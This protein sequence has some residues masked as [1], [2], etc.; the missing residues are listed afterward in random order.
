MQTITNG[1]SLLLGLH[2]KIKFT[3]LFKVFIFMKYKPTWFNFTFF[4]C[5]KFFL[6]KIMCSKSVYSRS[7]TYKKKL[8]IHVWCTDRFLSITREQN[9]LKRFQKPVFALLPY[10]EFLI[11]LPTKSNMHCILSEEHTT[12]LSQFLKLHHRK[13]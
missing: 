6:K 1:K 3:Y 12:L 10:L 2:L 8:K 4:N 13:W 7:T 5:W 11:R 9:T